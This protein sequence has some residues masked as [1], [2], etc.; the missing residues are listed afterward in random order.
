MI[1]KNAS[2]I[3][4]MA[5]VMTAVCVAL[6]ACA[7]RGE[8]PPHPYTVTVD[9]ATNSVELSRDGVTYQLFGIVGGSGLCGAAIGF[10]DDESNSAVYSVKGHEPADWILNNP[11]EGGFMENSFLL[12]KSAAVTE[13]PSDLEQYRE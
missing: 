10:R 3:G 7:Q 2:R 5:I 13:I 11:A 8:P 6:S 1:V 4:T 9:A 12:F